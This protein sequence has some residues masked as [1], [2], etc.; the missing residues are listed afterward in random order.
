MNTC[1]LCVTKMENMRY[2]IYGNLVLYDSVQSC[3]LTGHVCKGCTKVEINNQYA[4]SKIT[5]FRPDEK[6]TYEVKSK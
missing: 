4:S 5:L 6:I 1:P 3:R 2:D